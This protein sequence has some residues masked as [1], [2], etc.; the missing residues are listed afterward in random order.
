MNIMYMYT[1]VYYVYTRIHMMYIPTD[2][3]HVYV[4]RI[5]IMHTSIDEH[6]SAQL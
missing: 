3:Y 5:Y 1:D 6:R 2:E 4:P